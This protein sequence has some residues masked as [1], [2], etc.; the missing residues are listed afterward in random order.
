MLAALKARRLIVGIVSTGLSLLADRV[1]EEHRLDHAESNH[2]ETSDG[3]VTGGVVI[4]IAHGEKGA[5]LRRF[6]A[7]FSIAP[8]QVAAVGDTEGDVSMFREA[9]WS[10]AFNPADRVV[11]REACA[12]VR[13]TD[14]ISLIP[15]VLPGT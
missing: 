1:R 10:V 12:V 8:D 5:A 13:G 4:S 11:E 14:L 15:A 2:L 6:C 3:V 9:G 7:S